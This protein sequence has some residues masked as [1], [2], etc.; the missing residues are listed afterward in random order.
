MGADTVVATVSDAEPTVGQ[1]APGPGDDVRAVARGGALNLV[2]AAVSAVA[3]VV[4]TLVVTRAVAPD[5]AGVLFA[6]TSAFLIAAALAR[7]GTTTGLVYW[8]SRLRATGHDADVGACLRTAFLPVAVAGIVLGGALFA[9]AGP[10]GAV[11]DGAAA[12]TA[13]SF[14]R[15]LAVILPFAALS[16]ATLAATRGLGTMRPTVVVERIGRPIAQVALTLLVIVASQT[17]LLALA[18]GVPYVG[19]LVVGAAWLAQARPRVVAAAS[20]GDTPFSP[21]A[22]WRYTAPRLVNNL[23]Q[24]ALQRLDIVLVAALRGPADAALYTVATRFLVVGQ[25]GGQAVATAVEPRVA[26]AAARGDFAAAGQLYRI[27]TAWLILL[28]WPLYLACLVLPDQLLAIFGSGYTDATTVV[29]ILT[30]AMLVATAC[31]MVDTVLNMAGRTVWTLANSTVA[32][33]VMIGLDVLLVPDHGAVGAAVGWMAAIL[34][35]NLLPLTQLWSA[36]GI[37]PFGRETLLAAATALATVG[38]V[39]A[40]L[41]LA[42]AAVPLRWVVTV[43]GGVAFLVVCR[44]ARRALAVDVLLTS[45]RRRGR[46]PSRPRG[47]RRSHRRGRRRVSSGRR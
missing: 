42:G 7:L 23:V 14:L 19:A 40:A 15:G 36:Y 24:M 37:H 38:V 39:P 41:G 35:N 1:A 18:W 10:L 45:L 4:L 20:G 43:A 11:I 17:D 32:L 6:V 29:V 28:T 34:T 31:G 26:V 44:W 21:T 25:L 2:G 22:F 9:L 5:R 12:G 46:P 30:G 3:N 16:D 13:T 33:V 27:A 8:V 47:H